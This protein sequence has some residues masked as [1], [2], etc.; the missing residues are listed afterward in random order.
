MKIRPMLLTDVEEVVELENTTWNSHNSPAQLPVANK[1]KI[2]QAFEGDTHFLIAEENGGIVGVL[3]YQ[4]YYPFSSGR[5]VVTFGIAVKNGCRGKGIGKQLIQAFL[6]EAKDDY[7]KVLIHVLSTNT[8]ALP[9]YEKL[10]FKLEA[11]LARQFFIDGH[12]TDDLIYSLCL[13][14]THAQ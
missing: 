10:G 4:P 3:D 6:Q 5:H 9:F 7:Q 1:D 11:H 13:E 14:E 8:E 12:Y 2:I